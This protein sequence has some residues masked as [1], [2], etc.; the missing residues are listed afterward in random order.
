MLDIKEIARNGQEN[1]QEQIEDFKNKQ[2]KFKR[3]LKR[4]VTYDRGKT[5]RY[6]IEN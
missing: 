1:I 4:V 3:R 5:H 2:E 6:I